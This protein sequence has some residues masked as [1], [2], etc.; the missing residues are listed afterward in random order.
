MYRFVREVVPN[1]QKNST[2]M[3]VITTKGCIFDLTFDLDLSTQRPVVST[4]GAYF[5]N[6]ANETKI[7]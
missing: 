1:R 2:K 7:I 5:K 4:S 3:F 6:R